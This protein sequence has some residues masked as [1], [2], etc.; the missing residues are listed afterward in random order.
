MEFA[1][2][3]TTVIRATEKILPSISNKLLSFSFR[4]PTQAVCAADITLRLKEK[5]FNKIKKIIIE[6]AKRSKIVKIN[7]E[8][9]TSIDL[10][11]SEFSAT[12]DMRWLKMQDDVLKIVLW[13]D[14]EWGY[15]ARVK[16]IIKYIEQK[17]LY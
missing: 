11:K 13:Y 6:N 14:N 1:P 4:I 5:N 15:T 8:Q 12:I 16:D 10:L 17:R 7:Y 9:I 3:N 2:K